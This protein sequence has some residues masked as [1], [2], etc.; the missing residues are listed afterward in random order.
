MH[1][2]S[3][4]FPGP[5]EQGEQHRAGDHGHAAD[6]LARIEPIAQQIDLYTQRQWELA[7]PALWRRKEQA[8]EDKDVHQLLVNS[9]FNLAVRET[10]RARE[11]RVRQHDH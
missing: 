4:R 9:Y 6:H 2:R 8:P 7:L 5:A 11:E 3:Y 10:E 1:G